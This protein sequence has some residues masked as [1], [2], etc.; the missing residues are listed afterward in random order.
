MWLV[1]PPCLEVSL[2]LAQHAHNKRSLGIGGVLGAVVLL[3]LGV[4]LL[5]GTADTGEGEWREAASLPTG[6]L[7]CRLRGGA[8]AL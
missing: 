2:F 3:R 7:L 8:T 4:I 1:V 6:V 5:P